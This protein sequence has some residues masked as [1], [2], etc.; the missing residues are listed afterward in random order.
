MQQVDENFKELMSAVGTKLKQSSMKSIGLGPLTTNFDENAKR[1]VKFVNEWP[2]NFV[3]AHRMMFIVATTINDLQTNGYDGDKLALIFDT[4]DRIHFKLLGDE[5]DRDIK[6]KE[7]LPNLARNVA[8][9]NSPTATSATN[10]NN[11]LA[12]LMDL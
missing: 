5:L 6:V 2:T 3:E 7:Y 8:D 10:N 11:K 1:I 4:L 9:P 12:K